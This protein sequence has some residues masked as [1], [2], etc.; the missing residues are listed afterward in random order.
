[1]QTDSRLFDDV[2]RVATSAMG[3]ASGLR[4]EFDSIVRRQLERILA[5]MDLVSRDEFDAVKEMAA[6]ARSEQEALAER[7]EIL[8]ARLAERPEVR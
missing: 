5:R 2:A 6:K 7:V 8:E 4:G 3:A 1:M